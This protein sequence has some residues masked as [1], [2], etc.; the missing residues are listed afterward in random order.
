M[1]H[2]IRRSGFAPLRFN[3]STTDVCEQYLGRMSNIR[4]R[5]LIDSAHGPPSSHIDRTRSLV[6]L[7]LRSGMRPS[8]PGDFQRTRRFKSGGCA[9]IEKTIDHRGYRLYSIWNFCRLPIGYFHHVIGDSPGASPIVNWVRPLVRK[10]QAE[11][12]C[13]MLFH[14]VTDTLSWRTTASYQFWRIKLTSS[15]WAMLECFEQYL[16]TCAFTQRIRIA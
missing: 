5:W 9:R 12:W 15:E 10:P 4:G 3:C 16:K 8:R 13:K 14:C 1:T 6:E 7:N 11:R 2:N